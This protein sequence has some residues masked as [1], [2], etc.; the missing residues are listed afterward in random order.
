MILNKH[1]NGSRPTVCG[2]S[3]VGEA[4]WWV[5]LAGTKLWA[6]KTKDQHDMTY[7]IYLSDRPQ[8]TP[9]NL[10]RPPKGRHGQSWS[11]WP[12]NYVLRPIYIPQQQ[13]WN[14]KISG[15]RQVYKKCFVF[16]RPIER[17]VSRLNHWAAETTNYILDV[18]ISFFTPVFVLKTTLFAVTRERTFLLLG[19]S[20]GL[21]PIIG[22]TASTYTW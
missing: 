18:S 12:N 21:H 19:D 8:E 2:K 16:S 20:L 15:W 7:T 1:S 4:I 13:R 14:I 6:D 5:P 3:T 10:W 11:H 17:N 9:T 22:G